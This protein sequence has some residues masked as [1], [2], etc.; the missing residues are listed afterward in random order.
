MLLGEGR[1]T[2]E[3][4]LFNALGHLG[5]SL[6]RLTLFPCSR[7][8]GVKGRDSSRTNDSSN[9]LVASVSDLGARLPVWL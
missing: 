9:G 4:T 5:S 6:F 2:V 7:S 1:H 8:F 3:Q